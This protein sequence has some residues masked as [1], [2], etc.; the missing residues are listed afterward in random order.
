MGFF[1]TLFGKEDIYGV[2]SKNSS[3]LFSKIVVRCGR[4]ALLKWS[5]FPN[6]DS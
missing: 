6:V 3:S 2:S 5:S 1:R 4:A